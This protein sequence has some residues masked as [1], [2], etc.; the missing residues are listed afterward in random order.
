MNKSRKI[1]F[2]VL[3]IIVL[4]GVLNFAVNI[5]AKS[6]LP[7]LINNENN[8]DYNI[9]YKDI[10]LSIWNSRI[11]VYEVSIS[12]KTS[13]KKSD[14]KIGLFGNIEFIEVNQ[15]DIW[16]VLFGKKIK[17]KN[18]VFSKPTI[19]LYKNNEKAINDYNSI[20]SKVFKP[21]EKIIIV[22]DLYLNEGNFK[23]LDVENDKT[24]ANAT[25]IDLKLEGIVLNETTLNQKI[26]VV[27]SKF[28]LTCDSLF[29]K[30]DEFYDLKSKKVLATENVFSSS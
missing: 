8:T 11:T 18:L 27:Y 2:V 28:S 3:G 24:L 10:D 23:I 12:P 26:P 17:A 9:S 7:Q 1:L 6:K 21:F 22:S 19:I 5:W 4:L 25:N 15:F 20:N 30:L 16:S 14:K 29:Y 13:F